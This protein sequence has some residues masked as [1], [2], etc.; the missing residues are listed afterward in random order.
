M[1]RPA[2]AGFSHLRNLVRR[3]P[4]AIPFPS[5]GLICRQWP[6]GARTRGYAWFSLLVTGALIGAADVYHAM[7]LLLPPAAAG[8]TA[9]ALRTV[10]QHAHVTR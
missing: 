4:R 1:P 7:G 6:A 2:R 8:R 10:P 3:R 5:A 9:R